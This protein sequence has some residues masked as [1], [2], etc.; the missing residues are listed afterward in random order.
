MKKWFCILLAVCLLIALVGCG[1]TR[2]RAV[3]SYGEKYAMEAPEEALYDSYEEA[4]TEAPQTNTAQS[5]Q[6]LIRRARLT[7]ETEDY[8]GFM[9]KINAQVAELG[10]YFEQID[11]HTSGSTLS[12]S[13]TIRVPADKLDELTAKLS[14]MSNITYRSESQENV[15]MQYVDTESHISALKT[16]QER[17]LELLKQAED[18]DGILKIEDKL[19]SVRY[20]LESAERSLRVL[21]NQVEYA[22]VDLDVKQVEVFT[23]VQEPGFWENIGKGFVGSLQSI[24]TFLKNLFSSFVI[25][26]PYLIPLVIAPLI[27]LLALLKSRKRRR[28]AAAANRTA[29]TQPVAPSDTAST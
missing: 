2:E 4:A 21:A 1:S 19:A 18:L 13:M 22:T 9:D 28:K 10:G 12:A 5:G 17:L 24:W 6:K 8:Y 15:T 11:A 16:E 27:V 26:L 20:E 25:A 14:G 23:P 29:Q 3:D 7:V